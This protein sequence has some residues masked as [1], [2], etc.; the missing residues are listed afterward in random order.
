MSGLAG[1][2]ARRDAAGGPPEPGRHRPSRRRLTRRAREELHGRLLISPTLL[3]VGLVVLAPFAAGIM[4]AFQHV[5]LIDIRSLTPADLDFTLRNFTRVLG[6]PGFWAAARTTLVYATLTTAGSVLAG[7]ALA[8]ALRRPFPG[9][10]L[11]RGLVLVPYVLPVVA[12]ATVWTT[13]LN[14]QYGAVNEMG[15]RFLGWTEPV[16]FLTT[17]GVDVAGLPVPVALG[18]VVLFEVWK[19]F[20]LAFLFVTARLQA[21]PRDVEEAA[22]IDG[23]SPVQRFRHVLLPQLAGVLLLL[24]LLRFI[25]SFQNFTDV[26]LLTGGAGGTEVVG[27]RVYQELVTRADIG[28]ASALGVLMTLALLVPLALYVRLSRGEREE[29]G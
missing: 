28:T 16:N 20:P 26:Y 4:L 22:V 12:A 25:W 7:L 13:L 19:S 29:R 10:G 3:V 18:V 9:R 6:G 11:L 5:R 24:A 2:T 27:V 15:R 8:L 23:A 17:R 14:P 1:G 21:V